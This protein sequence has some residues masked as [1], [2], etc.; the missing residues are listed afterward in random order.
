M[1]KD[2]LKEE[3]VAL[4]EPFERFRSYAISIGPRDMPIDGIV[5]IIR[6]MK[7]QMVVSDMPKLVDQAEAASLF[8]SRLICSLLEERDAVYNKFI[9]KLI[10]EVALQVE[11]VRA[12]ELHPFTNY[13]Q[14]TTDAQ[15]S[16]NTQQDTPANPPNT[17]QAKDQAKKHDRPAEP[18]ARRH[19]AIPEVTATYLTRLNDAHQWRM[20]P[21]RSFQ[22]HWQRAQA[23]R[24]ARMKS[25]EV[26]WILADSDIPDPAEVDDKTFR[27]NL[28]NTILKTAPPVA[29]PY[30]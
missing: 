12:V 21:F 1:D 28:I 2:A 14:K 24:A 16:V 25:D 22:E 8:V 9:D 6:R 19:V 5:P 18:Q 30:C 4:V 7:E 23:K 11:S 29:Y 20:N 13:R 17:A 27:N 10:N 3:F 15:E 26:K